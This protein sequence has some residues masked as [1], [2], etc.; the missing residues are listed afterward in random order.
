MKDLT[1]TLRK[2]LTT[3][4]GQKTH[5][6]DQEAPNLSYKKEETLKQEAFE[7]ALKLE[8]QREKAVKRFEAKQIH[9]HARADFEDNINAS[10]DFNEETGLTSTTA[11]SLIK[12]ATKGI[13]VE[14]LPTD[15]DMADK[16]N[17]TTPIGLMR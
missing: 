16:Y 11:A 8:I 2:L 17:N 13:G 5:N 15:Q 1:F 9:A 3:I 7:E 14:Y 6:Q 12:K 4:S 10:R